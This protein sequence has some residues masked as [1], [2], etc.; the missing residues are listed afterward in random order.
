VYA[1]AF[2]GAAPKDR[3]VHRS[4]AAAVDVLFVLCPQKHAFG[5][6][7]ALYHALIIVIG[8]VRQRLDRDVIA[9]LDLDQRL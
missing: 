8:M 6:G 4:G 3:R 7:V 2:A 5:A 9:G 1:K